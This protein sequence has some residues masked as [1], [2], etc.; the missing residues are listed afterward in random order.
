MYKGEGKGD[1]IV[2]VAECRRLKQNSNVRCLLD[3]HPRQD[4]TATVMMADDT[5][6]CSDSKDKAVVTLER[7]RRP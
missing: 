7:W 1:A 6:M 2:F 4:F 3:G 5:G